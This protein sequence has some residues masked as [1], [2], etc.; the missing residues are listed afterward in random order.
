MPS[1]SSEV[2]TGVLRDYRWNSDEMAVRLDQEFHQSLD[3]TEPLAGCGK[4]A[5]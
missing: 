5:T 4:W 3:R 1:A 2:E